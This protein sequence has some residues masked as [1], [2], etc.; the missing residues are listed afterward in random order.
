MEY[1]LA[2]WTAVPTK[3]ISPTRADGVSD[4]RAAVA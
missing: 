2:K 4:V 3:A 1:T